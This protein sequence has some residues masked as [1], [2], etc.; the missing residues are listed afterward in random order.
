M[1]E[2]TAN[3]D[4]VTEQKIDK[5]L[6]ETMKDST[7]ITIAHRLNTI[8]KCDRVLVLSFGEVVEFDSPGNL[9]KDTNSEFFKLC[10]ELK[11]EEN[12]N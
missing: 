9:L 11:K 3:I 12:I 4:I 8:M 7:V 1:D 6:E 2:A 5:L 10:E